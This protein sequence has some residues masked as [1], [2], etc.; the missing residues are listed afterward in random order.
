MYKKYVQT[1][2][3]TMSFSVTGLKCWN[4][5]DNDIKLYKNCRLFNP[6]LK[7]FYINRYNVM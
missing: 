3:K 6:N 7:Y 4:E 5:L 1:N 2:I